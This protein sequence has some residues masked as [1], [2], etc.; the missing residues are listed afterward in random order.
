MEDEQATY[1][2]PKRQIS[3]W[4]E[5]VVFP[6]LQ[7]MKFFVQQVS[8]TFDLYFFFICQEI[9]NVI[10]ILSFTTILSLSLSSNRF[11]IVQV[12]GILF[13]LY[14]VHKSMVF[15]KEEILDP[16]SKT[17]RH[18]IKDSYKL[19]CWG[20]FLIISFLVFNLL[21]VWILNSIEPIQ[22]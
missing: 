16:Y 6:K 11:L 3:K 8:K 7:G 9:P 14:V 13:W 12:V 1:T 2:I 18:D 5:F 19:T 4:R 10:G 22:I 17:N 21:T 15:L 20:V